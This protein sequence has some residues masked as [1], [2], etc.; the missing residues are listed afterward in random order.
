[1]SRTIHYYNCFITKNGQP[2]N[3]SLCDLLDRIIVLADNERYKT[4]NRNQMSL[5][6]MAHPDPNNHETA[7]N[8]TVAFCKYRD[9]KP[10]LGT[11]GTDRADE[12]D[13][14]VLELTSVVFIPHHHMALVE[15]NHQGCRPK[16]ISDY[17]S[18][19]LP[20]TP[21]ES[22]GV[23]FEVISAPLGFND[24][25]QSN[26]IRNIEFKLD[27]TEN[28]FRAPQREEN[29]LLGTLVALTRTSGTEV[30]ANSATVSFGN[31]RKRKDVI[32]AQALIR[33]IEQLDLESELFESVKVKY[34]SPSTHRVEEIDI[35]NV[36]IMK[37]II[38]QND[39][40]TAWEY[41]GN[42][43]Q[44]NFYTNA[45][46]GRD[47]FARF[48]NAIINEQFPDIVINPIPAQ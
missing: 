44:N 10:F 22:W 19:F 20:S 3:L 27:I 43:I 17:L 45:R 40:A 5:I 29:S 39:D 15:Y 21:E 8:R 37:Q 26:D 41:I 16:N 36:G 30:G 47:A 25:R 4:I 33:L 6:S 28:T 32:E 12:I 35:K 11:K 42:E 31:G 24:I 18:S 1:M 46:P 48:R 13:D 34:S 7:R 23:S 38:M 14:D 2:T 9:N